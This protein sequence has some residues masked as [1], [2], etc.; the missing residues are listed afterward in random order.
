MFLDLSLEDFGKGSGH[1][2]TLS[3][4]SRGGEID[5]RSLRFILRLVEEMP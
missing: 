4:A 2:K 1:G 5:D 3:V